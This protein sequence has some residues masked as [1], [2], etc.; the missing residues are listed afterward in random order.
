MPGVRSSS[1]PMRSGSMATRAACRYSSPRC[2]DAAPL[3]SSTKAAAPSQ[4]LRRE[5]RT[6]VVGRIA[7]DGVD[8]VDAALRRVLDDQRRSLHAEIRRAA[9]RGWPAPG[10]IGLRQVA[11]DFSQARCGECVVHDAG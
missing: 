5:L 9:G 3:A 8:V 4:L 7:V 2:A 6:V 11:A 10:E 1:I